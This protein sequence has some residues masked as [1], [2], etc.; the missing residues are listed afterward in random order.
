MNSI[1]VH[2]RCGHLDCAHVSYVDAMVI[3]SEH[4]QC[5]ACE[6]AIIPVYGDGGNKC[7][8]GWKED[9]A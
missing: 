6:G 9:S 4:Y 2:Q 8:I 7:R 1:S 3:D 5:R